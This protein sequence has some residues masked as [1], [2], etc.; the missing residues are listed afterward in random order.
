LG[1]YTLQNTYVS[2]NYTPLGVRFLRDGIV[3]VAVLVT[4]GCVAVA[5]ISR[6]R[7][8]SCAAA[9]RG[10]DLLLLPAQFTR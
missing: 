8:A 6:R 2:P 3:S 10:F 9:V 5:V 4:I 7:P 1:A